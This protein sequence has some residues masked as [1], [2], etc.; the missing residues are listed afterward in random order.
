MSTSVMPHVMSVFDLPKASARS[1]IV[2]GMVK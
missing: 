1:L 2:S